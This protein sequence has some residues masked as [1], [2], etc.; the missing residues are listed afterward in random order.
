MT[1]LV[2]GVGLSSRADAAEIG[3]LVD[4]VLAAAGARS[5]DV[6]VL[7]TLADR[8]TAPALV[9]VAAARGWEI[10]GHAA[11]ELADVAV[12][13]PSEAVRA[14]TGTP[15]VAEAAALRTARTLGRAV[16]LVARTT[17]PHATAA[18]AG[19]APR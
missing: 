13:H 12:P 3:A 8:A 14:R 5:G 1:A 6:R 16:L 11:G 9:E 7:A 17:T 4:R 19:A 18:L 2:V 15:S 10:V